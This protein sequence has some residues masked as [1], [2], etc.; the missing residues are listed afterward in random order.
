MC[1]MNQSALVRI[2]AV[3]LLF[4]AGAACA[5]G[6]AALAV[7]AT[8]LSKNVCQ[9]SSST[10]ALNFGSLNPAVGTNATATTSVQFI[11]H[12]SAATAAYLVSQNSGLYKT[13]PNANRMRHQ[14]VITQFLPY[15][16]ALSP[17]TGT[18]PK[19]VTQ[20]LTIT[21]TVR[22]S[23]YQDAYVGSYAD[24]VVLTIVP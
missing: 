9:F 15:S 12:G 5:A 23:D 16:L 18:A 10:A 11:C 24:T 4:P 2:C 14:T 3:G 1:A 6:T 17:A 19:N 13:A 22:A 7:T 20:T 21:G 8:V